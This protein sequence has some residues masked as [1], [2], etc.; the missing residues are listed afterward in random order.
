[1]YFVHFVLGCIIDILST[2]LPY[3]VI[4]QLDT[5]LTNTPTQPFLTNMQT[6][7]TISLFLPGFCSKLRAVMISKHGN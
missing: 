1:M 7:K 3:P 4:Y 2:C 5:Y 6:T